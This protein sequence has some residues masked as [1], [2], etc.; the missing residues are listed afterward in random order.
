MQVFRQ[1]LRPEQA[2]GQVLDHLDRTVERCLRAYGAVPNGSIRDCYEAWLA[3]ESRRQEALAHVEQ[4]WKKKEGGLIGWVEVQRN[5]VRTRAER[6]YA[7]AVLLRDEDTRARHLM[8]IEATINWLGTQMRE[9]GRFYS[10][11]DSCALLTAFLQH[12]P[13]GGQ[14]SLDG[15]PPLDLEQARAAVTQK[16][17]Q[18]ITCVEGRVTLMVDANLETRVELNGTDAFKVHFEVQGVPVSEAPLG[19]RV[20]VVMDIGE[21]SPGL[22]AH[23]ALPP[24]LA[25]EEGAIRLQTFQRDFAGLH[26]LR[27]PLRTIERSGS[28]P[29]HGVAALHNMFR[30]EDGCGQRIGFRVP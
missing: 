22:L 17:P 12:L 10:T 25:L 23:F 4:S 16:M 5:L 27:V 18:E 9:K 21:Y 26:L 20:D 19:T 6:C 29:W 14:I 7:A 8:S 2:E 11:P 1:M 15:S 13:K 24:C 30:E 28:Q 3:P